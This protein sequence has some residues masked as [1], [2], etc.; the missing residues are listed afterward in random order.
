M[1][2]INDDFLLQSEMARRLYHEV[3]AELESV[4]AA[5][6]EVPEFERV[7]AVP[8]KRGKRAESNEEGN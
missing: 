3:A 7:L 4:S 6:A 1:A 2:F 8:G 5:L